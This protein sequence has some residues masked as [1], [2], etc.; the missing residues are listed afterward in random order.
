[1]AIREVDAAEPFSKLS[2]L[3]FLCVECE[4]HGE[5]GIRRVGMAYITANLSRA[6]WISE[7]GSERERKEQT[8]EVSRKSVGER[9]KCP[10]GRIGNL[11]RM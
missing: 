7:I 11:K 3:T 6:V 4:I 10:S 9:K 5:K 1:M 8:K 2:H